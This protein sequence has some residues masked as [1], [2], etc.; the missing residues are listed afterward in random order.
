[1]QLNQALPRPPYCYRE[2]L[3][4]QH[5]R[6]RA[7]GRRH[8]RD[9]LRPGRRGD[10]AGDLPGCRSERPQGVRPQPHGVPRPPAPLLRHGAPSRAIP[11]GRPT[12]TTSSSAT[13]RTRRDGCSSRVPHG[14]QEQARKGVRDQRQGDRGQELRARDRPLTQP[15]RGVAPPY[16]RELR[17]LDA[18]VEELRDAAAELSVRPG[19]DRELQGVVVGELAF[20]NA[21]CGDAGV[22]QAGDLVGECDGRDLRAGADHLRSQRP[23]ALGVV[24]DAVVFGE[25]CDHR[26]GRLAEVVVDVLERARCVLDD[27]VEEADHLHLQVISGVAQDVGDRL[28]V[29]EPLARSGAHALVGIDQKGDR[30]LPASGQLSE[31]GFHRNHASQAIEHRAPARPHSRPSGWIPQ[32]L[33]SR[34][35]S[36]RACSRCP[37]A[38][39]AEHERAGYV[40]AMRE[41]NS[42]PYGSWS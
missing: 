2:V 5:P 27:V 6:G 24:A 40:S 3:L 1:M 39:A 10:H 23:F 41:A 34:R 7:A 8:R 13:A 19:G 12:S 4:Q 26:S 20:A 9:C 32:G 42:S 35:R 21:G 38:D 14:R 16:L 29:G 30:P 11:T 25:R 31:R 33:H 28:R 17:R 15:R 37:S 18:G 36:A 22:L